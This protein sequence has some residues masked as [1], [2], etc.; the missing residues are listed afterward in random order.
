[1]EQPKY[2]QTIDLD[3]YN[4]FDIIRHQDNI[5]RVD[6]YNHLPESSKDILFYH[7]SSVIIEYNHKK[8]RFDN[9]D[10]Y[11]CYFD[12]NDLDF[13]INDINI[14]NTLRLEV[15]CN[16]MLV[17]KMTFECIYYWKSIENKYIHS[18]TAYILPDWYLS[19][20]DNET[21]KIVWKYELNDQVIEK[22]VIVHEK[23]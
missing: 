11:K 20:K 9:P 12:I 6:N 22:P 2:P 23:K 18:I 17:D 10:F 19:I 15:I 13:D 4:D 3:S 1:M 14:L 5:I 21:I 7:N 16:G 8:K